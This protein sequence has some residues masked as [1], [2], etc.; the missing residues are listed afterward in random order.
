MAIVSGLLMV[1]G[2]KE[3]CSCIDSIRSELRSSNRVAAG[4]VEHILRGAL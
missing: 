3:T 2:Q 4:T 1:H